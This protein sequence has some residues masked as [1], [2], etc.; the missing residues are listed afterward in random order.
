MIYQQMSIFDDVI[1]K[2]KV[3]NKIRLIEFFGG[4]G[5][6]AK[7][8]EILNVPFEHHR[9]VEWAYNSY[10][11]YNAIHQKDFTD[12]SVGKTKE[13]MVARIR[14][15]STNYNEPLTDEQLNK[16]PIDWI[17]NA[18]NNCIATN[19]L[20]N[21]M[22]VHAKD[23]GITEQDKYTYVCCYS[24]PCFT[25]D[26]LVLTDSGYKNIIDVKVNDKVLSHDNKWHKVTNTFN[27]G[28]HET[29]KIKGM[30]IDE[31]ITTPNHKFYVRE[32]Y[33][34]G[35]RSIR[36]FREPQWLEANKLT[37]KHYLGIAINQN[38]LISFSWNEDVWWI[39][40]RYIG[41]GWLNNGATFICC[42][43]NEKLEITSVL[44]K[45]GYHYSVEEDKSTYKIRIVSKE[46]YNYLFQFGKG[47]S[48]KHLTNDILDLPKHLLKAFI[49]GYL[50]ADGCQI[51]EIS[52]ISTTSKFLAY[53]IAQCIAKVYETPYRIYKINVPSKTIIEGRIVNQ[54]NWYQVVWKTEIRKQ[55]KAFYENGYIWFPIRTIEENEPFN[56][57]DIEVKDSHSFTANGVIVHNCQDLSMAGNRKGMSVSQAD[58]GTRSGLLWEVE[59]ILDE[60]KELNCLPQVLLMENVPQVLD[61]V[62]VKD[63][64]KW[65]HKLETLGYSNFADVLNAKD[66]GIPQ[67]RRREFMVSILG[68]YN[69]TM[70]KPIKLRHCLGDFLEDDSKVDKKYYLSEKMLNG[71]KHTKFNSY[72][73]EN[74]LQ[75]REREIDTLTT[76]TGNRCPHLL[77][78]ES[79]RGGYV[80][81]FDLK[82][83][84]TFRPTAKT[85]IHK[86]MPTSKT[87]TCREDS[88][89]VIEA[90]REREK[91]IRIRKLTP[92]ECLKLMGFTETDY[93]ALRKIGM[94]DAAIYHM[95]GDSIVS[96]VL[97]SLFSNLVNDDEKSHIDIINNYVKEL[98]NDG[99]QSI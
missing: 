95:S 84:D 13:E 24:F 16:K 22:S 74:R 79:D 94:S 17:K 33:R 97:V 4:I 71:M 81:V 88:C 2:F 23:L 96:T 19:N 75:E 6:Q 57:Y 39:I 63:W 9:L 50:S 80:G 77:K 37:K 62:N 29:L 10:C 91:R 26:T 52:K 98:A 58:G 41:D 55:D 87:L 76:A 48:N 31:I 34:K 56:V 82:E 64:R 53:G 36:T 93:L 59:R 5:S 28:I 18:Y 49:E 25:A 68:E 42:A 65:V 38:S 90:E 47:A 32:M 61:S 44:D 7:A 54:K 1:P 72:K 78:V 45:I 8:L 92:L 20:I 70:P 40:G 89:C 12:Y 73:L 67:N 11:S 27:N 46:L 43:K 99:S 85:R 30:G 51:K 14:G 3:N 35:H 66:Y 69:Y 60:C 86:D 15:T 21:I 83:S